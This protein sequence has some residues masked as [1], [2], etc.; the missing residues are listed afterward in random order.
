MRT[1]WPEEMQVAQVWKHDSQASWQAV[2]GSRSSI[3][4]SES[5]L[6]KAWE[7]PEEEYSAQPSENGRGRAVAGQ[8]KARMTAARF[9]RETA[10]RVRCKVRSGEVPSNSQPVA[11]IHA[12]SSVQTKSVVCSATMIV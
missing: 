1:G 11:L 7:V 8:R 4:R 2:A 5:A 12:G 6:Q 10:G 9:S 3:P